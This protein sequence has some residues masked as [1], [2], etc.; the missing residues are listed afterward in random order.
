VQNLVREWTHRA[1]L[2]RQVRVQID[3]DPVSFF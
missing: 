2:D 1:K 3:V